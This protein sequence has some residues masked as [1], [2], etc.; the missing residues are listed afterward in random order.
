MSVPGTWSAALVK[1]RLPT[2][3]NKP[4]MRGVAA[5]VAVCCRST[6]VDTE[7]VP[8]SCGAPAVTVLAPNITPALPAAM[9]AP[10]TVHTT[11][12]V[13]ALVA[14]LVMAH[15]SLLFAFPVTVLPVLVESTEENMP[16]G[17]L[18]VIFPEIG[19]AVAVVNANVIKP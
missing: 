18:R 15:V 7:Y 14:A 3:D 19:M 1:K 8:A 17:R 5:E 6:E 2:A 11:V 12:S 10:V 13:S 16:L 4:P 9:D